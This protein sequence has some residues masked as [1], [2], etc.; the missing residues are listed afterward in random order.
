M[1]AGFM[2]Y[3]NKKSMTTWCHNLEDHN[4]ESIKIHTQI[5]TPKKELMC[6]KLSTFSNLLHISRVPTFGPHWTHE[7]K[8]KQ[9]NRGLDQASSAQTLVLVATTNPLE[10]PSSEDLE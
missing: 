10:P 7:Y 4:P 2:H 8:Q 5:F 1:E 3:G 6:G 9:Q